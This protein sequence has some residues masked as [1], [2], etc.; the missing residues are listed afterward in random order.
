M[1]GRRVPGGILGHAHAFAGGDL[2]PAARLAGERG[3]MSDSAIQL[4]RR[5]K[6]LRF[7]LRTLLLLTLA[8]GSGGA[9]WV[10]REPWIFEKQW[11]VPDRLNDTRK[12]RRENYISALA[13][14]PDD[15]R[16]LVGSWNGTV[17]LFN[18]QSGMEELTLTHE[19][20]V[21]AAEFAP[22]GSGIITVVWH[23]EYHWNLK[24]EKINTSVRYLDRSSAGKCAIQI[25][26]SGQSS[27]IEL[28]SGATK[29]SFDKEHISRFSP[30]GSK[31]L[32]LQSNPDLHSKIQTW[33]WMR[34]RNAQ[35]GTELE[36]SRYLQVFRQNYE[37]GNPA[38]IEF[39]RDGRRVLIASD[40]TP[41]QVW[42]I[43]RSEVK[44][45]SVDPLS[46]FGR[47]AISSDGNRV[48]SDSGIWDANSGELICADIR[49]TDPYS[50][51]SNDG[52]RIACTNRIQ[53]ATGPDQV[54]LSI[55]QRRRPE[56]WWGFAWLPEFWLTLMLALATLWSLRRDRRE[57]AAATSA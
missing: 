10:H 3:G 26:D 31:I 29:L 41:T 47:A 52:K 12:I 6:W 11:I 34:L 20:Q 42:N 5:R 46:D 24:G 13:F 38:K 7:S 19:S 40:Y 44:M 50:T 57:N 30:D 45:L 1:V 56:W 14:S 28:S 22:D 36:S 15:S 53:M 33:G 18:R 39:S 54:V 9:L 37:S 2:E 51:F 49:F 8:I 17:R 32:T 48:V 23:E 43:Q 55:Y 25:S 27:I 16:V 21:D 4:P 35:T